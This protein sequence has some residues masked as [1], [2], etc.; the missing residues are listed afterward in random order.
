MTID[1]T[2]R[3]TFVSQGMPDDTFS[4]VEF[5]GT[6]GISRLY[7]FDITLA[8]DD[9]EIDLKGILQNPATLTIKGSDQDLPIHGAVSQFEQLNEVKGHYFYRALLVPRLWQADLYRE[10]Q[11]FLDK[12]VPDI[13]EEI[14]KQAGLTT[15]D[16]ELKL[17]KNYP[18]W[19]YICQYRETDFDFI[20]RWMEREG[21]YFYF[22]QEEGNEK[23]I[24]TDSSTAH[25]DIRG[26]ATIP[27]TPPSGIVPEKEAIMAF[28]CRQKRLP[29]KVIL[30]DYNYR[31]PS[32]DLKAEAEVDA[33]GRG[34]V[35]FYG[36]HF[37][38]PEEGNGLAK[39]RAEEIM[40][41]E[42][43]YHGES[44]APNLCPGFFYELEDHYR[45]N[46]NQKYL[47]VEVEH[48]GH[49]TGSFWAGVEKKS[50]KGEK[51]LTYTNSFTAI[52]SDVQFRPECKTLKPKFYGTMNANIDAAGSGEYAE[53]DDLGRYKVKL[54][55][56]QSD[57]EGGK[58]SRWVRMSQ[59]YAGAEHGM[60][61]PLHKGTEVL[62]TFVD[63]DPDRPVIAGA[64][65]NPETASPVTAANQSESVI[66]TGGN[67]K[68]RIQ[69]LVGSERIIMETPAANSWIRVGTP[70]DPPA[71]LSKKLEKLIETH[72]FIKDEDPQV[73]IKINTEGD[74]VAVSEGHQKVTLNDVRDPAPQFQL[75]N[76]TIIEI[77]DA[78]VDL[79]TRRDNDYNGIQAPAGQTKFAPKKLSDGEIEKIINYLDPNNTGS[80]PPTTSNT[81]QPRTYTN[82]ANFIEEIKGTDANYTASKLNDLGISDWEEK[83]EAVTRIILQYA[84]NDNA[85][86][87]TVDIE[88]E[89]FYM[90][91]GCH[92][93]EAINGD[94][95]FE[96]TDGG[97]VIDSGDNDVTI[98]CRKF[99][100]LNELEDNTTFSDDLL[101][102]YGDTKE[103]TYGT[104]YSEFHGTATELF[105]GHKKDEHHGTIEEYFYGN[106]FGHT[107]SSVEDFHEGHKL[108]VFAGSQ[109][110][111]SFIHSFGLFLG[112]KEEI[113]LA[114]CLEMAL[115][116]TL[117]LGWAPEFERKGLKL[118]N[119]DTVL[120]NKMCDIAADTIGINMSNLRLI[121]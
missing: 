1:E 30:K 93:I 44:T 76:D 50:A 91:D 49:Q 117:K 51:K 66:K 87:R 73:G 100:V 69:D 78:L 40:C 55:F 34:D 92:K 33:S 11:L 68:I 106:K 63:G 89:Q 94:L 31:K 86:K 26:D 83:Q 38:T 114:L 116:A 5:K 98:K 65:P 64:V 90:T 67:N 3:F 74:Y 29:N 62:L 72:N 39:I 24:I 99:N 17:T 109:E 19:E 35:Y 20:S 81:G 59:P 52:R 28:L 119:C 82:K 57:M 113:T 37:K 118:V 15:Q 110:E 97:I 9:P 58:A 103:Y 112:I 54:P 21:I 27:F 36:E 42:N 2:K 121:G 111:F 10:N 88:G 4:V 101:Y 115:S 80:Y 7:E 102:H 6:E 84:E 14:L 107:F 56:D 12:T 77:Y 120:E 32:L 79:K 71:K 48:E 108:E 46:Y 53:L 104:S 95:K 18:K 60:H 61:F 96:M 43:V 8:S 105:Y 47:I 45:Q 22:E 85:W 23:L 70:N 25:E 75:S 41:R 16:Y 13:I